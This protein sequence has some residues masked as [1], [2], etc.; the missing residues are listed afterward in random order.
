MVNNGKYHDLGTSGFLYRSNK[1]MYDR[2]TQ[3]LW[4]TIEGSPVVGPLSDKDIVLETC[5]P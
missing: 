3:S 1:L 5:F 4:N 2:K